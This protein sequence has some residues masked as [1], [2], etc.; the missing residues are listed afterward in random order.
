[1]LEDFVSMCRITNSGPNMSLAQEPF[2]QELKCALYVRNAR[3][4]RIADNYE[5]YTGEYAYTRLLSILQ[6]STFSFIF[7]VLLANTFLTKGVK[8]ADVVDLGLPN[9]RF[10][11]QPSLKSSRC[12]IHS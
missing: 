2:R 7:S 6:N 10:N 8:V 11:I 12:L 5:L 9:T 3:L 1:M 4:T